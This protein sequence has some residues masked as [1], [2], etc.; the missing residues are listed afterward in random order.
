MSDRPLTQYL[1]ASSVDGFIAD[2]NDDIEWL[3]QFHT[4]RDDVDPYAEFIDDVGALAMGATTYEWIRRNDVGPW[5]YGNRPTWVFTHRALEPIDGANLTLTADD[6]GE[7]HA[8]MLEAAGGKNVWLVGGGDLVGQFLDHDL[9]DEIWLSIAPVT[10]GRGAPLLPRRHT[11][12]M[13]LT[14]LRSTRNGTFA[15]LRYSLR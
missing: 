3:L 11:R 14:S 1:V 5:P 13:R 15:H 7:V 8:A 12:P 10:L 2:E 9:L 4:E 6:V